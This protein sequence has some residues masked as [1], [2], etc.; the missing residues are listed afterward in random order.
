[1]LYRDTN[2]LNYLNFLSSGK[3]KNTKKI[4]F[5]IQLC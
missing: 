1:M 4:P 2:K 3:M 5:N